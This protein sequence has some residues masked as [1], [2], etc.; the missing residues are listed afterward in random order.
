MKNFNKS[1]FCP[2][3]IFI[4]EP[5][6]NTQRQI[7]LS[8]LQFSIL[9]FQL[10][11]LQM[12]PPTNS[13]SLVTFTLILTNFFCQTASKPDYDKDKTKCNHCNTLVEK[14]GKG[15][16]D[17][18][19]GNYGGGNTAWEEKALGPWKTSESRLLDILGEGDHGV[20]KKDF[21]CATLLENQEELVEE[22][23]YKKQEVDMFQFLCVDKLKCKYK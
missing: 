10:F 8:F 2:L 14:F 18:V 16:D 23:F 20:C 11:L 12:H 19:K 5:L 13:P 21:G 3:L 4:P 7:Y 9:T 17:T 15:M 6:P 1:I 22:W